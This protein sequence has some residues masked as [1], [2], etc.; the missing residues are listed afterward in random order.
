MADNASLVCQ[1][2]KDEVSGAT[3]Q[4]VIVCDCEEKIFPDDHYN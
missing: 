1:P 2:W 4:E 3:Y